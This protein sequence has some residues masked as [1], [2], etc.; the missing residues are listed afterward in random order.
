[1]KSIPNVFSYVYQQF[2]G[3]SDLYRLTTAATKIKCQFLE[4]FPMINDFVNMPKFFFNYL[5]M[6]HK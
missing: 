2:F 5:I 4:A 3:M 6:T 1:M